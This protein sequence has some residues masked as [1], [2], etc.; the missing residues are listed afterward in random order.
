MEKVEK[1]NKLTISVKKEIKWAEFLDCTNF[2]AGETNNI[3]LELFIRDFYG[4]LE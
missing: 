4:K 2:E 3:A 1:R